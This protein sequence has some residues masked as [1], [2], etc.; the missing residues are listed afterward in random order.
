VFSKAIHPEVTGVNSRQFEANANTRGPGFISRNEYFYIIKILCEMLRQIG[1]PA[2]ARVSMDRSEDE[3]GREPA[4][5]D[6]VKLTAPSKAIA[7][8]DAVSKAT[9]PASTSPEEGI[10]TP[11]VTRTPTITSSRV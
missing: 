4:S 1:P 10:P 3:I 7:L 6:R 11:W 5:F 8:S 9:L 2:S